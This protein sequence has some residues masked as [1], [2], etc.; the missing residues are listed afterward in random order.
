MHSF[1]GPHGDVQPPLGKVL[2]RSNA[3]VNIELSERL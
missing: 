1:A 3:S 2:L